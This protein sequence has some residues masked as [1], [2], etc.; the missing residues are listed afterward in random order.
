M[1]RQIVILFIIY[2]FSAGLSAQS[3]Q[4]AELLNL[5][6]FYQVIEFPSAAQQ[7]GISGKVLVRVW[8]NADSSVTLDRIIKSPDTLFSQEVIQKLTYLRAKPALKDEQFIQ[9]GI[10]FPIQFNLKDESQSFKSQMDQLKWECRPSGLC[11]AWINQSGS[12]PLQKNKMAA[13][14][15]TGMLEDGKVFDTSKQGKGKPFLVLVGKTRLIQGWEE[16]FTFLAP[17]DRVWLRIPPN[18]GYGA[19]EIE[20]IPANS[21][22]YFDLEILKQP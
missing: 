17:G 12:S 13:M 4:P 20:G 10:T 7:A 22:L 16:A 19:Q 9:E 5:K 21:T 1:V 3:Y 11:Y 2:G 18:L 15:Y 14:H 8:V 6:D